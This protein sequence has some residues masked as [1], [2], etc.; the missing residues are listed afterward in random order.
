MEQM[1]KVLEIYTD[2]DEMIPIME[3]VDYMGRDCF[4]F[5]QH[6]EIFKVLDAK[7]M[8]KFIKQK[9]LGRIMVNSDI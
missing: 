5:F 3:S 9:W 6:F 8:D 4:W 1:V 7:I 2:I